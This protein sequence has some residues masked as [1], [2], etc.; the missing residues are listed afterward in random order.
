MLPVNMTI[1]IFFVSCC[2]FSLFCFTFFDGMTIDGY[3]FCN[4]FVSLSLLVLLL[5]RRLVPRG[6]VWLACFYDEIS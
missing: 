6:V 2:L 4:R 3:S 5:C 1:R